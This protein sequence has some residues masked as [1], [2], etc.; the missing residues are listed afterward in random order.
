[1]SFSRSSV[2]GPQAG[3]PIMS[4][5]FATVFY[6]IKK[7][8]PVLKKK[9]CVKCGDCAEICPAKAIKFD[10]NRLPEF[11]RKKCISCLCCSELCAQQAI[12]AKKRGFRGLFHTF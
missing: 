3:C 10:K 8:I 2:V 9:Y 12:I 5:F 6:K 1:M 4:R 11:E 7:K